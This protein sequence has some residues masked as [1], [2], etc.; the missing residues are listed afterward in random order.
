MFSWLKRWRHTIEQEF[1]DEFFYL[2]PGDFC[3]A[4]RKTM[5]R[6]FRFPLRHYHGITIGIREDAAQQ[7][8]SRF[9]EDI[10]IQPL[11]VTRRLCG[12]SSNHI[13]RN[14]SYIEHRRPSELHVRRAGS[15]SAG[16]IQNSNTRD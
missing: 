16:L 10:H 7:W 5:V 9:M 6:S 13:I 2:M 14:E 1:E 11:E 12:N 8:L 15:S 4:L 3:I